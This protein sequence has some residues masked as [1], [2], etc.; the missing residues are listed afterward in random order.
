MAPVPSPEDAAAIATISGGIWKTVSAVLSAAVLA[1]FAWIWKTDRA[2]QSLSHKID[3]FEHARIEWR[4]EVRALIG[5][6]ALDIKLLTEKENLRTGAEKERQ[7]YQPR[8][9]RQ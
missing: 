6:L 1:C 9:S 5:G 7:R 2:V 8:E 3:E 4:D